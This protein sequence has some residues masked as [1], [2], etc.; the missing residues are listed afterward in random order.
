[1]KIGKNTEN[2]NNKSIS[3]ISEQAQQQIAENAQFAADLR[4]DREQTRRND[5]STA[6]ILKA[7]LKAVPAPKAIKIPDAEP[8]K[9]S[10]PVKVEQPVKA[11][12]LV[13]L[14]DIEEKRMKKLSNWEKQRRKE[15]SDKDK[16]TIR[17]SYR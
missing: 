1:M 6:D 14:A 3:P 17:P 2:T 9:K 8:N 5:Q 12:S 10:Q 13:D 11:R 15:Q 16:A 7:M 4:R